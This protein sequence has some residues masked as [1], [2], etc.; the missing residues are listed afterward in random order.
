[1]NQ[2]SITTR[3]FNQGQSTVFSQHQRVIVILS[4]SILGWVKIAAVIVVGGCLGISSQA[5]G[6]DAGRVG[7]E[8]TD[9]STAIRTL[10]GLRAERNRLVGD[11]ADS[12]LNDSGG[13]RGDGMDVDMG[14][15]GGG[16]GPGGMGWGGPGSSSNPEL[17][18]Q[19][20]MAART[21][22]QLRA[23]LK[24]KKHDRETVEKQLRSALRLYFTADLMDRL[25]EFDKVKARLMDLETKLQ[26]RLD[27]ESDIIE[28][29]LK[30]MLHEADGLD[31]FVP[32]AGGGPGGMGMGGGYGDDGGMGGGLGGMGGDDAMG[33]FGGGGFGSSGFGGGLSD[34]G[35]MG[36]G[37]S[38]GYLGA[39]A[40][41]GALFA[42]LGYDI[43]HGATGIL[44]QGMDLDDADP[45]NRLLQLESNAP[46]VAK[47]D[48]EKF[49]AVLLAFHN[50]YSQFGHFP[51]SANRRT[52]QEPPH[53]WRVAILP[54]L[55]YPELYKS[56]RFDLPW[57]SPENLPVARQMP[58]VYRST[59]Q[60]SGASD[61]TLLQ[62]LVGGGAFDTG[63]APV[64]LEDITDGSS[65]TIAIIQSDR[66][67][68]W[69]QPKDVAYSPTAKPPGISAD[70]LV[71]LADGSV[72]R[73]P[74][75]ADKVMHTL[76]TR[77]GGELSPT[78]S[79]Q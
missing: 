69:T 42:H 41:E 48:Q 18:R 25:N 50:F 19:K 21:V 62:M 65:N 53:S 6:Q 59:D 13:G 38:G 1:M 34:D 43:G 11:P 35:G 32:R 30:Q 51:R 7:G 70:R 8:S 5:L 67:V 3:Q 28:L 40:D 76:I 39:P 4:L 10:E 75:L 22:Q 73:L 64:R 2:E 56:Y 77:A 44:R 47:T 14:G 46:T 23:R 57:D 31:F 29:Q 9:G 26:R 49:A 61:K 68:I 17:A 55:G 54:L 66:E 72:V 58:D 45:L 74:N 15:L 16:M 78:V 27:S 12:H 52:Q 36:P 71:G 60:A 79:D 63:R 24:S 37:G 20:Q 33:G